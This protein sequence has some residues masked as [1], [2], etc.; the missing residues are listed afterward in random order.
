MNAFRWVQRKQTAF[1]HFLNGNPENS[2]C[3]DEV[4][5]EEEIVKNQCNLETHKNQEQ[6]VQDLRNVNQ[7]DP[8]P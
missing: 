3:K 8:L 2:G 4:I 5:H 7:I 6:K 1:K